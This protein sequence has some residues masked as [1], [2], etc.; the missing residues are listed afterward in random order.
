ML[1]YYLSNLK[2][3]FRYISFSTQFIST[4]SLS[5]YSIHSAIYS[6]S[7]ADS[8][9]S[10]HRKIILS[11][12]H[13]SNVRWAEIGGIASGIGVASFALQLLDGIKNLKQ[14]WDDVQ[15]APEAI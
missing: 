2:A 15:D 7:I 1:A 12:I 5:L 6:L 11:E 3:R 8:Y 13:I 9:F 4:P 14:F 10:C